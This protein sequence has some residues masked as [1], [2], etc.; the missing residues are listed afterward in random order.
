MTDTPPR[1][2]QL[3]LVGPCLDRITPDMRE[4]LAALLDLLP[5]TP[6]ITIQTDMGGVSASRDWSSD[7]MERVD[8]LADAIAAAPGI[9]HISVPDHR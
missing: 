2:W 3:L 8:Q 7:R 5:T 6:V 4:K 9:A 1:S